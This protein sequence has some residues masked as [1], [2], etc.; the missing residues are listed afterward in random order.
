MIS[1]LDETIKQLLIKKGAIDPA[2]IDINFETPDREWSTSISKPTI[3]IYLYDIRENHKLRGTEWAISKDDNGNATKKKNPS[4]IDMSY[5]ITVWTNDIMDE[6]RLL[7]HVL[8]TLFR[9]HQLPEELLS[10]ELSH[11]E[12]PIKT[13]TAQPDGLFNNPVDFWSALDNEIKPSIYYVVTVPL[14]TDIAFTAPVVKTK[15]LEIKP[16]DT[17]TESLI[18]VIGMVHDAGK[19]TQGVTEAMVVVKEAGMTAITDNQGIYSFAKL[20][21]GEYTFQVLIPGREAIETSI[22]VPGR[23]YDLEV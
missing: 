16:P 2:E 9:Y 10:G 11:A 19:P 6:H 4:R 8:F 20:T 12:Y 22:T 21:A 3:N 14:D 15:V 7:W 23:T 5:L 13:V 17:D 1:G 18:Q